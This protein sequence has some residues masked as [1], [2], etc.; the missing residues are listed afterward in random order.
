MSFWR[1]VTATGVMKMSVLF[2]HFWL[3]EFNHYKELLTLEIIFLQMYDYMGQML[4]LGRK[5]IWKTFVKHSYILY[6]LAG[7]V[8]LG[9]DSLP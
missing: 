2:L 4:N 3:T 8:K 6:A 5:T 1:V 7:Q 9:H